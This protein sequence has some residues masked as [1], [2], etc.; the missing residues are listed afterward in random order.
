MMKKYIDNWMMNCYD[1]DMVVTIIAILTMMGGDE[2]EVKVKTKYMSQCEVFISLNMSPWK[3]P[4]RYLHVS[5]ESPYVSL[6]ES[7]ILL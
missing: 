4:W 5:I 7:W 1:N 2:V 3:S 6:K